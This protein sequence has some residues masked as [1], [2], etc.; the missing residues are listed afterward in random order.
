M[1]QPNYEN[2]FKKTQDFMQEVS[3]LNMETLKNWQNFKPEDL[4][5]STRPEELWE[6]QLEWAL[7]NGHKAVEYMQQSMQ[8][9]EKTLL[10]CAK[11]SRKQ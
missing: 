2:T 9:I 10:S 3:Q 6:K 8:I 4:S 1:S 7:S 11:E 5:K